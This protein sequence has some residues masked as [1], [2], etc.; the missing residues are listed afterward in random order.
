MQLSRETVLIANMSAFEL[1]IIGQIKENQ[2]KD[3]KMACIF[4]ISPQGQDLRLWTA[5][6]TFEADYV[7]S[8]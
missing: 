6:Y 7:F 8:M 5:S 4:N 2:R 1:V 3:P